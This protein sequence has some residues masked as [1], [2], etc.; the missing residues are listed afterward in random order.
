MEH[1]METIHKLPTL[2]I[3][4]TGGSGSVTFVYYSE[5]VKTGFG[6]LTLKTGIQEDPTGIVQKDSVWHTRSYS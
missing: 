6:S 1:D 2:F 4:V 3:V 5:G